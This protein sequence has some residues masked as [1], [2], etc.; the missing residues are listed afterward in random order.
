MSKP[1]EQDSKLIEVYRRLSQLDEKT[2]AHISKKFYH[3][4]RPWQLRT[5]SAP[6]RS[7][8]QSTDR[9]QE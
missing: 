8:K 6:R 3:G 5:D 4:K 7:R 2:Q 9:E 1:S